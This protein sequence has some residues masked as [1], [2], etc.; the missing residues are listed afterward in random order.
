MES[1]VPESPNTSSTAEMFLIKGVVEAMES[2]ELLF[3]KIIEAMKELDARSKRQDATTALV[4]KINYDNLTLLEAMYDRV[5]VLE[6]RVAKN[7]DT[8]E[9]LK[10]NESSN[11]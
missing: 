8:I 1:L 3:Q 11:K 5:A 6:A 4:Q 10:L 2:S 9:T 7:L